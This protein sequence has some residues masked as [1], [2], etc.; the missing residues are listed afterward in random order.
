MTFE[1]GIISVMEALLCHRSILTKE[2]VVRRKKIKE[3][4]VLS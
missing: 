2:E 1:L 4:L 3:M